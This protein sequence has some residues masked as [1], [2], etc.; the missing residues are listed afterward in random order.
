MIASVWPELVLSIDWILIYNNHDL[1]IWPLQKSTAIFSTAEI[2]ASN[3]LNSTSSMTSS[4]SPLFLFCINHSRMSSSAV[5]SPNMRNWWK[6][7]WTWSVITFIYL[8]IEW[9]FHSYS[10]PEQATLQGCTQSPAPS[11]WF[12]PLQCP[13][14][15][16]SR[17]PW[18]GCWWQRLISCCLCLV[19][20]MKDDCQNRLTYSRF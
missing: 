4:S 6:S 1:D 7:L 5:I 17:P 16:S 20:D 9:G 12:W 3:V 14:C 18:P 15:C 2:I 10:R 13:V 11:H 8:R 19:R